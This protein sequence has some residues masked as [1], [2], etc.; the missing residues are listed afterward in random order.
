MTRTATAESGFLCVGDGVADLDAYCSDRL[1]RT[2]RDCADGFACTPLVRPPCADVC[3]LTGVPK[4]HLCIPLDQIGD[5]QAVPVRQPSGVTRN[6]CRPRK[7]CT[8]CDTDTDCLAV[9]RSALRQRRKRHEDLHP[10]VRSTAPFVPLG[11]LH[12]LRYVWDAVRSAD[13]R[14]SLRQMHGHGQELRA[15]PERQRTAVQQGRMPRHRA[16]PATHWCVDLSVSCSC[17]D[18]SVTSGACT[19]DGCPMSPSG[20]A[21]LMRRRRHDSRAASAPGCDTC[22]PLLAARRKRAAGRRNSLR[23]SRHR[24]VGARRPDVANA[25]Q[26]A[27]ML[28]AVRGRQPLSSGDIARFPRAQGPAVHCLPPSLLY[29]RRSAGREHAEPHGGGWV[30]RA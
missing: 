3:K 26:L 27:A 5:G 4:D 8:S 15:V 12:Q 28:H 21:M 18:C 10:A 13:L 17:G 11:Q 24:H 2:T 6:V 22:E 25:W 16:S 20:L 1:Q 14:A 7:F 9:D 29:R 19:G 23:Q 30:Q